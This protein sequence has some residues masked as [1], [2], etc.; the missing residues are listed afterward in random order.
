MSILPGGEEHSLQFE[1]GLF[2]KVPFFPCF[3]CCKESWNVEDLYKCFLLYFQPQFHLLN[4][5]DF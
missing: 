5:T 4:E 1:F 3:L 2:M